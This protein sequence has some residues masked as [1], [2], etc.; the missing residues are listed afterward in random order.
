MGGLSVVF[1]IEGDKVTGF[2]LMPPQ[3]GPIVY[4]RVESK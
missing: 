3:G 2:N 4:T 1:K